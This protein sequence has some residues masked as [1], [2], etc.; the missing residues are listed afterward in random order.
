MISDLDAML[1][2]LYAMVWENKIEVF[3][4]LV[5]FAVLCYSMLWCLNKMAFKHRRVQRRMTRRQILTLIC[6][7]NIHFFYFDKTCFTVKIMLHAMVCY[8]IVCQ[9]KTMI[10]YAIIWYFSAMP[11][12]SN[13]MLSDSNAMLS[14][15]NAIISYF[16]AMLWIIL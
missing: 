3:N 2:I 4:D 14:D 5:L 12:Y 8:G 13:V 6:N 9:I 15:S 16:N 11:S 7:F 10:L 1:C